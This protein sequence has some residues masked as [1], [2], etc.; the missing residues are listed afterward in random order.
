MA[1]ESSRRWPK[2]LGL[3][4]HTGDQEKALGSWFQI[5]IPSWLAQWFPKVPAKPM[6]ALKIPIKMGLVAGKIYRCKKQ[7]FCDGSHFFQKHLAPGSALPGETQER[8]MQGPAETTATQN[9][10]LCNTEI[11]LVGER[12][13]SGLFGE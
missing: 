12:V 6:V 4:T 1:W 10:F 3:C 7:P 13:P 11:Q 2:P 8:I 9:P 5:D